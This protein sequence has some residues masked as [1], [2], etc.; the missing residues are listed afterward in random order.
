[1]KD[2]VITISVIAYCCIFTDCSRNWYSAGKSFHFDIICDSFQHKLHTII[3]Y[4]CH[5]CHSQMH[6]SWD[7]FR[8]LP[9]VMIW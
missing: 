2:P 3:V 9:F 1:M 4:M 8:T 7:I 6:L 5:E